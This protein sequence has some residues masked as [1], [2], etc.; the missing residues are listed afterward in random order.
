MKHT[1]A[2]KGKGRNA[3]LINNTG[4]AVD[5]LTFKAKTVYPSKAGLKKG[6]GK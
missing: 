6:T 5:K 1:T 2:M 3:H 4:K